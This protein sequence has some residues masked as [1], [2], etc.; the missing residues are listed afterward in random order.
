MKMR[1]KIND[2]GI[3]NALE[4]SLDDWAVVCLNGETYLK[5]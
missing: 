5:R 3:L 2:I 1:A 4:L